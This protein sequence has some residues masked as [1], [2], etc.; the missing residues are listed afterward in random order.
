MTVVWG[1]CLTLIAIV[2]IFMIKYNNNEIKKTQ[3]VLSQL[4]SDHVRSEKIINFLVITSSNIIIQ[5]CYRRLV[6]MPQSELDELD[7]RHFCNDSMVEFLNEL[8]N[9]LKDESKN[10]EDPED[11]EESER[12]STEVETLINLISTVDNNSSP[13]YVQQIYVEVLETL[14]NIKDKTQENG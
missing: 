7:L 8:K 6:T 9:R 12:L 2:A 11:G 13:E 1:V 14:N 5:R 4:I 3:G 10:M